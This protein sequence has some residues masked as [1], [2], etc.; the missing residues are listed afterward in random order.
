MSKPFKPSP[1][2]EAWYG[3][4]RR[5]LNPNHRGYPNYGGRGIQICERWLSSFQNF[6]ADMGPKPTPEHSLDR[7]DND[8]DYEPT[9]CR[10]TTRQVQNNNRRGRK[11]AAYYT[12]LV[13]NGGTYVK[14]I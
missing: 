11:K 1:E 13:A 4:R 14:R 10:W 2:K 6:Y 9:N 8:G 12:N 3:I 5:C 7:I